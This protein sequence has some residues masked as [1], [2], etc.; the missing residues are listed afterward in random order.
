VDRQSPAS[1][2]AC[3][4]LIQGARHQAPAGILPLEREAFLDL[5]DG[6]DQQEGVNAFLQK[7][8]PMWN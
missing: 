2:A 4:T 5:F 3:K 1:V 6:A 7:R 8:K